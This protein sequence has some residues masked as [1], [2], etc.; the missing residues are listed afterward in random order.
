[1]VIVG[2]ASHS[3][4]AGEAVLDDLQRWRMS[5]MNGTLKKDVWQ[6]WNE[7]TDL[8]NKLRQQEKGEP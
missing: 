2:C 6:K 7:E 5:A 3:S 4:A 8:I 1:M